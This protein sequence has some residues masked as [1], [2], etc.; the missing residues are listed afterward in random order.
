[1]KA[2]LTCRFPGS[3][4]QRRQER[5][6]TMVLVAIAMVAIIAMAA[7]S[8][9]VVT[10]YLARMEAQRSA[11]AAALAAARV[12]ALSGLT[13]DPAN[14]AG[15]WASICGAGPI[16]PATQAARA[17]AA[18]GTVGSIVAP[19][20]VVTYSAGGSAPAADCSSLPAAFG[21]NPMVTVQ[22]TRPSL[23][24][25]FSRI[26]GST[27]N[28]VTATATAEAFNPSNS[29]NVGNGVTGTITPVTPRCVKP[30]IIPNLDPRNSSGCTNSTPC[31][32]FVDLNDGHVVHGGVSLNGTGTSGVIG[33]RFWLMPD[34]A[35]AGGACS[36]FP[37]TPPTTPQ[38]NYPQGGVTSNPPTPNLQYLP[39]DSPSVVPV[40]LPSCASGNFYK[41]AI[42]GCDTTV[43]HCGVSSPSTPNQVDMGVNPGGGTNDTMD[44]VECLI[45]EGDATDVQPDGQDTMDLTAYPFKIL[46][47]T[48]N[49]LTTAG[50]ASGTPV[51]SSTS[52][53]TVPIYDQTTGS[54]AP[55]GE[56]NVTIVG[57]LQVF[58]NS[59]DPY[60]NV[61]VTILNVAGCSNGGGPDPVG[62]PVS[63]TSPVPVRLISQ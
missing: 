4:R 10:L 30:W 27:G 54:I 48:S 26:W 25:F 29:G 24:T 3:N 9:D 59:V 23:P 63:G 42:G 37:T 36:P 60:G 18:Q 34:C 16:S 11:D 35:Q 2:P 7:L 22:V 40:A 51:T 55:T 61:D 31:S 43:Y 39:G 47:G 6:V 56:S 14:S 20:V 28:N 44:A 1:M 19:T 41:E 57:F 12:I 46:A 33:E 32:P 58:I 49:P 52:I 17:V 15:A 21:V 5:G 8:I 53:V 45:H 38:A 13:G 50:L 62:N